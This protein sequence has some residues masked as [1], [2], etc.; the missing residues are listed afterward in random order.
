[1]MSKKQRRAL[2][3]L[4][5]EDQC[6]ICGKQFPHLST[7]IGGLDSNGAVVWACQGCKDKVKECYASGVYIH[8]AWAKFPGEIVQ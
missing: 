1:M 8:P 3:A 4:A 2:E 5:R 7:Q 6:S